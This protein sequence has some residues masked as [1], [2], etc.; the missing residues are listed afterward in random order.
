MSG[1]PVIDDRARV[2][3]GAVLRRL[4]TPT[5]DGHDAGVAVFWKVAGIDLG[6]Y[7][8]R[9]TWRTPMPSLRRSTRWRAPFPP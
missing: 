1:L 9:Y 3:T 8:A 6:V 4:P 7:Q 2:R 5:P